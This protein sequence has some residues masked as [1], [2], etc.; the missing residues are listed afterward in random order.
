M[1]P[2]PP[3][4]WDDSCLPR[5][6]LALVES[7]DLTTTERGSRLQQHRLAK[8]NEEEQPRLLSPVQVDHMTF[9]LYVPDDVT[10][11]LNEA[12]LVKSGACIE[13]D[14]SFFKTVAELTPPE[15]TVGD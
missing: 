9:V 13:Y 10:I 1:G 7:K 4:I 2:N 6:I 12:K 3:S 11:L 15:G 5:V 8:M 14:E